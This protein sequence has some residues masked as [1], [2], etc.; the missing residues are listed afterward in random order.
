M[1][2]QSWKTRLSWLGHPMVLGFAITLVLVSLTFHYYDIASSSVD[3]NQERG[4][5]GFLYTIHQKSIDWRLRARGPRPVA[6][7]LA[8]LAVDERAVESIGR[9]PWPREVLAK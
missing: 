2:T 5:T 7:N 9:W 3:L 8:L 6:K 1:K 4:I